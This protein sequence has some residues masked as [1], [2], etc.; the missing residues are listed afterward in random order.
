MV[1]SIEINKSV[2]PEEIKQEKCK[3]FLKDFYWLAISLTSS[4]SALKSF[5]LMRL[6]LI[7]LEAELVLDSLTLHFLLKDSMSLQLGRLGSYL[8]I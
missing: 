4:V 1:G 2:S 3:S 5:E 6:E 8:P 7:Q